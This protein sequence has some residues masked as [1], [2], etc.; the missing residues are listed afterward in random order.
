[1]VSFAHDF[2][3]LGDVRLHYVTSGDEA[4]RPIVLLHGYPQTWF[5]WSE[6]M[7]LLVSAGFRCIAPDLRGLGDSSRP[8]SGYDKKTL[9]GD[10]R[11]LVVDHLGVRECAV[12]GHDWGGAVAFSLAANHAEHVTH[13]VVA[14]VAIPGDGQPNL[15]QGGRRWHHT[16]L[17]TPDLPEALIAGREEIFARWFYENYGASPAAVSEKA[18]SEYLRSYCRP[19]ALRSGFAYYRAVPQDILD[20]SGLEKLTVPS[21]AMGGGSG[22]GRGSEVEESLRRMALDVTGVVFEGCGHWIP[23]EK[24]REMAASIID[25]IS[26]R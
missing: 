4:A 2:A 22:W 13:L 7:P 6:I 1:M 3:D 8:F 18:V 20:N 17:Q 23:E 5:C 11:R 19:G 21:L 15:G 14:D 24:P 12:V 10:V 26:E 16:F 25:F 9:A